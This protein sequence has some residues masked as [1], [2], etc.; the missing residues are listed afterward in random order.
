MT[1]ISSIGKQSSNGFEEINQISRLC[2]PSTGSYCWG[3][4]G[5]RG[6]EQCLDG[7]DTTDVD[8]GL[9]GSLLVGKQCDIQMRCSFAVRLC[10]FKVT[11]RLVLVKR[12]WVRYRNSK[13]GSSGWISVARHIS[14]GNSLASPILDIKS[15]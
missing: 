12:N 9:K 11:G 5:D 6:I 14:T 15:A 8:R 13:G 1:S 10:L 4:V 2:G 7:V 3:Q